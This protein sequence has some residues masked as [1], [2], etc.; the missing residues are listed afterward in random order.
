[1]ECTW[2]LILSDLKNDAAEKTKE[3]QKWTTEAMERIVEKLESRKGTFDLHSVTICDITG[4]ITEV[5][6]ESGCLC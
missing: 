6:V 1:M 4:A 2:G 5:I 3:S